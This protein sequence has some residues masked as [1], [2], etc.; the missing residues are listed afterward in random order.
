MSQKNLMHSVW[1]K[2]TLKYSPGKM[3]NSRYFG[4]LIISALSMAFYQQVLGARL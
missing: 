3:A 1:A 4:I 2:A